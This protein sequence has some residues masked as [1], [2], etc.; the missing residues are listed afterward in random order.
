MFF[1][2]TVYPGWVSLLQCFF[3]GMCID[4]V[5]LGVGQHDFTATKSWPN[6][7]PQIPTRCPLRSFGFMFP[8]L[9]YLSAFLS[10]LEEHKLSLAFQ[11]RNGSELRQSV[12]HSS[13]RN[14]HSQNFIVKFMH[15]TN[16]AQHEVLIQ[17]ASESCMKPKDKHVGNWSQ[18]GI[19]C[20]D[21]IRLSHTYMFARTTLMIVFCLSMQNIL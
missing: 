12:C 2:V 15:W 6:S 11:K 18:E 1:L 8:C 16:D 5:M 7:R 4:I 17:R 14:T 19:N 20:S 9:F 3:S 21:A 10:A 13:N